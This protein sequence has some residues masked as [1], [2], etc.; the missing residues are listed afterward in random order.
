MA[1]R[2][3][4]IPMNTYLCNVLW[5]K[6]FRWRDCMEAEKTDVIAENPMLQLDI[7]VRHPNGLP[8]VIETEFG[9]A[10]NVE[11]DAIDRLKLTLSAKCGRHSGKRIEQVIALRIPEN[12]RGK[13]QKNINKKL[14]EARYEYCVYSVP[15][16]DDENAAP[17]RWPEDGWIECGIDDLASAIEHTALSENQ[18]TET[19][20]VLDEGIVGAS[21]ILQDRCTEHAS[22]ALREIALSLHQIAEEEDDEENDNDKKRK[23]QSRQQSEQTS[24]MA[25]AIIANALSF[26]ATIAGKDGVKPLSKLNGAGGKP[27]KRK[28]LAAWDYIVTE[29]NYYP[30]FSIASEILTHIPDDVAQHIL[31]RLADVAEDIVNNLGA[32]SQHDF[33]GRLFQKLIEDRKFLAT[34]YTLPTSATLLAELA[35]SRMGNDWTDKKALTN[36]RVADFA[37]GTGALLNAAYGAMMSRYRRGGAD[38]SKI[39]RRMMEKTLIGC[40][41]MPAATHLTTSVLSSAHPRKKFRDTNIITMR[42]GED[43]DHNNNLDIFIGALDLFDEQQEILSILRTHQEHHQGTGKAKK[44]IDLPHGSIDLVIMNPPFTRST[45]HD[46]QNSAMVNPDFAGL[47][48]SKEVQKRMSAKLKSIRPKTDIR[49]S[50]GKAGLATNFVDLGDVKVKKGGILAFVSPATLASG[51]S[52]SSVRDLIERNYRDIMIVSIAGPDASTG[53]TA[54]SADTAIHEVLVIGTRKTDESTEKSPVAYVTITRRPNSILEAAEFARAIVKSTKESADCHMHLGN[55]ESEVIGHCFHSK[56]G[57]DAD[58]RSI[59]TGIRDMHVTKISSELARNQLYLPHVGNL[60]LP[61][62]RIRDIG[63][64]GLLHRDINEAERNLDASGRDKLQR[65]PFIKV[66]LDND[67]RPTFPFLWTHKAKSGVFGRESRILVQPDSQ[68]IVRPNHE[69]KAEERWRKSSRVCVNSGFTLNSQA[70]AA[71]LTPMPVLGGSG[72]INLLCDDL[73]HE[74][75]IVLWMNTTLG[76]I[77][78]WCAGTRSQRGRPRISVETLPEIAIYDVR[79]LTDAQFKKAARIFDE[80]SKRDMMSAN[81]AHRDDVRKD[82]DRAVLVDLLGQPSDVLNSLDTLREKWCAEPTVRERG[83]TGRG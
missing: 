73:R 24:K 6:N 69:E 48:N 15:G 70:L 37:C 72:W 10:P 54:F 60:D 12:L 36:L 64:R 62:V 38:D 66:N 78:Y 20:K 43:L 14:E 39:H 83:D 77:S 21:A 26:Q 65:G 67:E 57:F 52:W 25:M 31:A 18:I 19:M 13:K 23:R 1:G 16:T 46:A 11:Q 5:T 17:F 42:Y 40:D 75:P 7:L 76:L 58:E 9:K 33:S 8:V 28:V 2:N 81:K 32:T 27:S 50:D 56:N 29:I 49:G 34:F 22:D 55:N 41:I 61:V 3:T 80:F 79:H 4:E 44:E 82:L 74:V 68:G 47:G 45:N 30:I 71:C 53:S 51:P 63:D 59:L 35:V